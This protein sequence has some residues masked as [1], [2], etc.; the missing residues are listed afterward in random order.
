MKHHTIG[1]LEMA[2]KPYELK[3]QKNTDGLIQNHLIVD[4]MG[5]GKTNLLMSICWG[6]YKAYKESKGKYGV[7]P[8]VFVPDFEWGKVSLASKD[9]NIAPEYSPE[10]IDAELVTFPCCGKPSYMQHPVFSIDFHDLDVEDI[11]Q[12]AN[13]KTLK[14]IGQVRK[15]LNSFG[16]KVV[17]MELFIHALETGPESV[18]ALYEVFFKLNEMGLFNT[19]RYPVFSWEESFKKLKPIIFNLGDVSD[20]IFQAL[21]GYLLRKLKELGQYKYN[22]CVLKKNKIDEAKTLGKDSALTLSEWDQFLL[23]WF[24]I[25]ILIDEAPT[26]LPATTSSTLTGYPATR[27]FK[28]LSTNRGRKMGIKYTYL[29]TQYYMDVYY[30]FRRRPRFLWLGSE[31]SKEDKD[32]MREN[33]IINRDDISMILSNP[34]FNFC[35]ID[36]KHYQDNFDELRRLAGA[37]RVKIYRSPCGVF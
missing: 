3:I 35:I 22:H 14:E 2:K 11:C 10:G 33:K 36:T 27:H 16:D 29:I 28:T 23:K 1:Y 9:D 19:S 37:A 6:Q 5:G 25:G 34:K 21:A 13:M 30:K 24:N 4:Q 7:L 31:V 32:Y 8:I 12:F 17:D 20:E 26:V 18:S 15:L